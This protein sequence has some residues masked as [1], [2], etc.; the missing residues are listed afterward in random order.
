MLISKVLCPLPFSKHDWLEFHKLWKFTARCDGEA[1]YYM[2][3]MV[4]IN[5]KVNRPLPSSRKP[6][7]QHEAKCAT[8]LVKISFICLRMENYFH[9]K[10]WALNLVLIQWSGRPRKWPI[11]AP[12]QINR[13]N[14]KRSWVRVI[15]SVTQAK[16]GEP[17]DGFLKYIENTFLAIHKVL[18]ALQ[19]CIFSGAKKFFSVR[20]F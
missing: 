9:I 5:V 16:S 20:P 4:A 2:N 13:L 11:I 18:L 10:G 19:K 14:Q 17:N 1:Y 12:G 3:H 15:S 6:H 8:F 7:F